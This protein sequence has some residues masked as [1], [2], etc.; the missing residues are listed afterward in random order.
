MQFVVVALVASE[1]AVAAFAEFAI[2]VDL[3]FVV[4]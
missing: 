3:E 2:G 1:V 4:E